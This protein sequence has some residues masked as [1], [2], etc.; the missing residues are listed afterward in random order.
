MLLPNIIIT[1]NI[2]RDFDDKIATAEIKAIDSSL[3]ER[4]KPREI[5]DQYLRVYN[6]KSGA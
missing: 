3:I 2:E 1:D 5:A 4:F 6:G